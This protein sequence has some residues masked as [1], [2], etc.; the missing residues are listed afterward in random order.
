MIDDASFDPSQ[1]PFTKDS[2]VLRGSPKLANLIAEIGSSWHDS[3]II[4]PSFPLPLTDP[5]LIVWKFIFDGLPPNSSN[6]IK[7]FSSFCKNDRG[8]WYLSI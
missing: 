1:L 7:V 6:R 8:T 2:L 4:S 3:S 5:T